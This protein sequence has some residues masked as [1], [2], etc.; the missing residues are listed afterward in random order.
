MRILH[1]LSIALFTWS[2]FGDLKAAEKPN[3]LL[4]VCDDLNDYVETLGGHP[5]V[6]TPEHQETYR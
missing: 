4:I 3:V 6:K 1:I 5:Q 2:L